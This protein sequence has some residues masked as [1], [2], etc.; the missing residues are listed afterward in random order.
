MRSILASIAFALSGLLYVWCAAIFF[1]PVYA[2]GWAE[3]W[4]VSWHEVAPAAVIAITATVLLAVGLSLM[5]DR[6]R[7]PA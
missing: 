4:R 7:L 1:Y 3:G 2:V 5:N 6:R